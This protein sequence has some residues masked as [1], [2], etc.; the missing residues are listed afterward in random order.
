MQRPNVADLAAVATAL[1]R[2]GCRGVL[3]GGAAAV[4][5]GSTLG[6][7][8]VDFVRARSADDCDRWFAFCQEAEAWFR[9]DLARRRLPPQRSHLA[10]RGTLLLSTLYGPVD[11]LGEL[12]DGR[13]FDELVDHSLPLS[14]GDGALRVLDVDTLIAVKADVGR[15]KDKLVVAELLALKADD[16]RLRS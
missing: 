7:S 12:H 10:G 1:G 16:A 13:G 2:H 6:T 9:R 14:L 15:P 8:D 11:L 5:H 3:I 4:L